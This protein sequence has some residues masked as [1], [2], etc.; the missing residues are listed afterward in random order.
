[1]PKRRLRITKST[2]TRNTYNKNG[3]LKYNRVA[4]WQCCCRCCCCNDNFV[5][6]SKHWHTFIYP[7]IEWSGRAERSIRVLFSRSLSLFFSLELFPVYTCV[8]DVAYQY[9]VHSSIVHTLLYTDMVLCARNQVFGRASGFLSFMILVTTEIVQYAL[10][11]EFRLLHFVDDDVYCVRGEWRGEWR[12]RQKKI[13]INGKDECETFECI[14]M[15]FSRKAVLLLKRI[16]K[17]AATDEIYCIRMGTISVAWKWLR[18]V[19]QQRQHG[20]H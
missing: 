8:T 17:T 3:I 7:N 4:P 12:R 1:M 13:G 9:T 20:Q 2:T 15:A 18:L 6:V 19:Q 10:E 16:N 11:C 14:F 5:L